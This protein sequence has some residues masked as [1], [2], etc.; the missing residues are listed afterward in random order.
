MKVKDVMKP[1]HVIAV[2]ASD[3]WD[4]ARQI[5]SWSGIR[6][7]PVMRGPA[8]VGVV[9]E[10]DLL[11]ESA[12]PALPVE[13]LM[14]SPARTA[15]PETNLDEAEILMAAEKLGCLPV[16]EDGALVAILTTTDLLDF[17]GRGLT[18]PAGK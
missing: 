4:L 16:L 15:T 3:S 12:D 9:S 6:H 13:A 7:L 2:Q 1:G 17:H 11:R 14:S 10:R 5:M 18:S 8:I